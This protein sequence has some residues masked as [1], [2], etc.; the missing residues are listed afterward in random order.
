MYYVLLTTHYL[1]FTTYY[2]LLTQVKPDK[3]KPWKKKASSFP[4]V[5]ARK[6][7]DAKK[8]AAHVVGCETSTATIEMNFENVIE[9]SSTSLPKRSTASLSDLESIRD[10]GR[11]STH[12]SIGIQVEGSVDRWPRGSIAR[13]ANS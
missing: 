1:L 3:N 5:L 9:L 2:L 11:D 12:D 10:L 13:F 6:T 4:R 7:L 8:S